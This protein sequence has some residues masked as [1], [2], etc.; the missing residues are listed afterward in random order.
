VIERESNNIE[1]WRSHWTHDLKAHESGYSGYIKTHLC[2]V[3]IFTHDGT[4]HRSPAF[5]T[6]ETFLF[7]RSFMRR[8]H[9][10]YHP[11]W[12]GRLANQF[13][14][15]CWEISGRYDEVWSHTVTAEPAG[16]GA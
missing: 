16:G 5:T 2:R 12:F 15:D 14:H 13:A 9:R 8:F 3:E 7:G 11:R 10:C 1:H 6:L 4:K